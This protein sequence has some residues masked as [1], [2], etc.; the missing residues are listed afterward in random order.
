M[1]L[2]DLIK[3]KR[4]TGIISIY[5]LFGFILL[6]VT[7]PQIK[8]FPDEFPAVNFMLQDIFGGEELKLSDHLGKPIIIYFFASW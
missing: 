6:A 8:G 4:T 1:T 3:D 2:K 7:V 5:C